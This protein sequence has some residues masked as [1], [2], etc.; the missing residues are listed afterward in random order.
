MA[1]QKE[2]SPDWSLLAKQL[3]QYVD[4][5]SA[6]A[7]KVMF[8]T[9]KN[10]D[11]FTVKVI[12]A[13]DWKA[14]REA[15]FPILKIIYQELYLSQKIIVTR[16][17]TSWIKENQSYQNI[18]LTPLG[19]AATERNFDEIGSIMFSFSVGKL[20]ESLHFLCEDIVFN[21]VHN[22]N[23]IEV[24]TFMLERLDKEGRDRVLNFVFARGVDLSMDMAKLLL[25][26][27]DDKDRDR[28]LKQIN[29]FLNEV[30]Q[31]PYQLPV[32]LVDALRNY[33]SSE[34]RRDVQAIKLLMGRGVTQ[35]H[36][37]LLETAK[38]IAQTGT[39]SGEMSEYAEGCL[40]KGWLNDIFKS[41]AVSKQAPALSSSITSS[42]SLT[43][44]QQKETA[45][46]VTYT[47]GQVEHKKES[48]SKGA[49]QGRAQSTR[50]LITNAI[51]NFSFASSIRPESFEIH[52]PSDH[53]SSET[54]IATRMS[55]LTLQAAQVKPLSS[56]IN[57]VAS[58]SS[59][60]SFSNA[61][62]LKNSVEVNQAAGEAWVARVK[63]KRAS[64][65]ST[66][67]QKQG[68]KKKEKEC[69]SK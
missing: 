69:M 16:D 43:Q 5:E 4:E 68:I 48:K 13:N 7:I 57:R 15:S 11:L 28:N 3:K 38:Q 2:H 55:N 42:P 54:A 50:W 39:V 23:D 18:V 14:I 10:V 26:Y 65:A 44:S 6:E 32:E 25:A 20:S 67:P 45:V 60:F 12:K 1:K 17:F 56:S 58:S 30:E 62:A 34:L 21:I 35:N 29:C 66:T 47:Q 52:Y 27:T 24:A 53:S 40:R 19:V 37:E 64:K 63:N 41:S 61:A 31:L 46:D 33:Q 49:D 36:I 59:S 9:L 51:Q 8:A 22:D